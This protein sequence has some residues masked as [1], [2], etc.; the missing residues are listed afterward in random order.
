MKN[1]G[2]LAGAGFMIRAR[3]IWCRA[4]VSKEPIALHHPWDNRGKAKY[5]LVLA[6]STEKFT[7][8]KVFGA[9]HGRVT[10]T[11]G[12]NVLGGGENPCL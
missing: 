9:W 8:A 2:K 11:M 10:S 4:N 5:T 3:M 7:L 12:I 6:A 1:L